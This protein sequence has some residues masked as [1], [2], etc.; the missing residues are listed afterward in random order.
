[1]KIR[2]HMHPDHIPARPAHMRGSGIPANTTRPTREKMGREYVRYELDPIK[3][4]PIGI[5]NWGKVYN[6]NGQ[7]IDP[8]EI[9]RRIDERTSMTSFMRRGGLDATMRA[10]GG[11]VV[12]DARGS[13][14]LVYGV[15]NLKAN[16]KTGEID[17]NCLK[18]L[19]PAEF[20][21]L[22][23]ARRFVRE[24]LDHHAQKAA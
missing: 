9:Q 3:G 10:D 12:V 23:E 8:I 21:S 11:H 14:I 19:K 20:A 18:N 24:I 1:M 16:K 4:V 7:E 6:H 17:T 2:R 15:K 22:K 13:T 5:K